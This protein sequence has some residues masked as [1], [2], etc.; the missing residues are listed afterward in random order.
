V[1]DEGR[2]VIGRMEGSGFYTQH[3]EAQR[4]YGGL[5]L[6]WLQEAAADVEPPSEPAAFVIADFGAASGGSSLEP[7]RAVLGARRGSGPALVVHTDIPSNDF[8]ALF[9][10]VESAPNTYLGAPGVFTLAA[11]QSFYHRLLPDD[12]LSLGW[13]SIA[14]HWL[15]EV[16]APIAD[17]IYCSFAQGD[18]RDA[19]CRQ[20]AH[21]WRTF[22]D[23]RAHELRRSGRLVILGGAAL[24]DGSSGAEGL[25][26]T[27]N[28]SLRALAEVGA[29][30][31]TEYDAMMIPTWNRTAAE[32]AEPFAS[33]D[34]DGRL[35]LR[36]QTLASLPDRYFETYCETGDLDRYV[37]AVADFF[38]AAFEQSLWASLGADRGDDEREGIAA[39]F[40]AELRRRIAE[41]PERAECRW[42]VALLDI[43][44]T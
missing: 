14:V 15:S 13:S 7:I 4:A 16:P 39:A 28:E 29:I 21:D 24:D 18:T 25:M 9:E 20:S 33:G 36:R 35:E 40:R 30:R 38:R 1:P 22:L 17:H 5:G 42:H 27:A 44:A 8:S 2:S 10:L 34:F 41:R 43:A 37:A 23:H 12:F 3:S 32:F 31:Q 11:G 26:D 6:A 19:L